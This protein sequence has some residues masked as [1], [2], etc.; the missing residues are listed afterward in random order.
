MTIT[1]HAIKRV[2]FYLRVSTLNGQTT[3]NQLLELQSVAVRSQWTV[4]ATFQDAGISGAK[5]R[6]QRPG[7][8]ALMR[9]VTRREF[10]L[11]AAWSVDRIGRSLQHLVSFLADLHAKSIDLYLHVQGID[12]TTPTGRAMFQLLGVFG[13]LERA[14]I[15][16][17][18]L[19]GMARARVRGTR[20]G[21]PIGRQRIGPE[22]ERGIRESLLSGNG[23]IKTARL[24]GCGVGTVERVKR[25]MLSETLRSVSTGAQP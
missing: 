17:R 22:K 1:D 11:V 19:A 18:I 23:V 2:A 25:A 10:D 13:E 9:G 14:I 8:D 6:D 20:S 24:V 15:R 7:L 21:K 12:T 16:E 5:G 3:E 4:V